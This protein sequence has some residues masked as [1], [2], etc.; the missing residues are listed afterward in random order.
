MAFRGR[1][2]EIAELLE[3][4]LERGDFRL[5]EFGAGARL[6]LAHQVAQHVDDEVRGRIE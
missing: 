4:L 2:S 5:A 1:D 6:R 3:L